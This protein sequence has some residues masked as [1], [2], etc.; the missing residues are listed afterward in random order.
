MEALASLAVERG[1]LDDAYQKYDA[2]GALRLQAGQEEQ[3]SLAW[4]AAAYTQ[5]LR[6]NL[7][8]AE[9]RLHDADKVQGRRS[10]R[11]PVRRSRRRDARVGQG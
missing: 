10:G 1:Q 11:G 2:I 5:A 4:S 8:A 9:K 6:G 3:A 7:A